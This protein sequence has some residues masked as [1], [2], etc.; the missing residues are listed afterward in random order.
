VIWLF[1]AANLL[2]LSVWALLIVAPRS[3]LTQRVASARWP[4]VILTVYYLANL[5]YTLA[6]QPASAMALE[7][8]FV[9]PTGLSAG[10]THYLVVDLFVGQYIYRSTG[11]YN[12]WYVLNQLLTLVAAP[13]GVVMFLYRPRVEPALNQ[14]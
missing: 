10:W 13:L 12:G 8:F 3:Q 2:A 14:T 5:V 7:R 4:F 6:I 9:L 11:Q 1:Y